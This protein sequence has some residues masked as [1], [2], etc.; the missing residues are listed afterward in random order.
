MTDIPSLKRHLNEGYWSTK[1]RY[2]QEPPSDGSDS[3]ECV[4]EYENLKMCKGTMFNYL[5]HAESHFPE[6]L[7]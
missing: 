4:D 5:L 3:D 7:I 2:M 1:R 6:L